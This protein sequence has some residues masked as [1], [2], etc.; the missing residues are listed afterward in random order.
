MAPHSS[1]LAWKVPWTEEPGKLQFM[2]LLR[3]RHDWATSLSLFTFMYWRR[4]W[5]L[6]PVFLPGESQ[7]RGSLVGC[8]LG[9]RTESDRT[10]ATCCSSSSSSSISIESVMPSNHLILCLPLPLP[11]SIF[12]IIRVFSNE[13]VLGIRWP[14]Y[15]NFSFSINP[16]INIQDWFPLGW[17]G[18]IFLKSKEL[19]RV[20]S[21]T[22][23][24][25][26]QFF[27]AHFL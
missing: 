3:V 27:S 18:W 23:V 13:S 21:N 15:W 11:P 6:I 25:K 4:K 9:G 14:K 10:E 22:T 2:G 12:L 17:T 16:S 20:F 5:Q 7:G 1:I 24:Q 8:H 19:S 26:L